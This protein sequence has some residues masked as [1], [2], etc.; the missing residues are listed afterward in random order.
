VKAAAMM[1]RQAQ[2]GGGQFTSEAHA[3][4]FLAKILQIK[5]LNDDERK[6]LG[7]ETVL[8]QFTI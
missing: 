7:D 2:C 6:W 1:G 3:K 5:T 4:L 8:I